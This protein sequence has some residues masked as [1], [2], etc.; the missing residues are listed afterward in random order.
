MTGTEG[1]A[2]TM[3]NC[4]IHNMSAIR[5]LAQG[6]HMDGTNN[7]LYDCGQAARRSRSEKYRFT[8]STC[9]HLV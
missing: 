3:E 8:H 1:A 4:V 7:L 5:L 9:Q 2:V 6:A